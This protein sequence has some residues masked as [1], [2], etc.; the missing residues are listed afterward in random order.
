MHEEAQFSLLV[1]EGLPVVKE[2]LGICV[3]LVHAGQRG[4]SQLASATDKLKLVTS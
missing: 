4:I 1:H 2:F 3:H